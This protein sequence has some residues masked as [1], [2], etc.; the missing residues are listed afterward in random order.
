[1]SG[2][3]DGLPMRRRSPMRCLAPT[4]VMAG[5]LAVWP[6]AANDS[7]AELGTGG[8]ILSRTDAIAMT[9]EELF[10][11]MGRVTVDYVFRN[12]TDKDVEAVVAF[13]MPTIDGNPYAMPALPDGT[14]DNFL[15]FEVSVDG[16]PVTAR[17][18]QR[19]FAV[20]LDVTAVLEGAGVPVNPFLADTLDSLARLPER[21]A[22]GWIERGL[23]FID[24]YD[25]GSGWKHVRTPLWS[26]KSTYWWETSFPAGRDV[27]VSHRYRPSV[28]GTA[29]LSFFY[30]GAFQEGFD[31]YKQR[32]CIDDAFEQA[33]R[34]AAAAAPDGYPPLMEARIDYVLTT[35]GN[36]A[37]GTI[38][39]FR[40]TVDKGDPRNL[41]S[42]CG[43]GVRKT[44][45]TTFEMAAKDFYPA[46][47]LEI[48]ILH[49]PEAALP[50]RGMAPAAKLGGASRALRE[51]SMLGAKRR[52]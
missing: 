46:R 1:M 43:S 2:S 41:V 6:A 10:V 16:R 14:S 36:W 47:D 7:I 5:L 38:G 44:G 21:V 32:Y 34:R 27:R 19:A 29:G 4:A 25:D 33:V 30:D 37:L 26:L 13:P 45:T 22:Q 40:L 11:S 31:D 3:P 42:F 20:G 52:P 15:G 18:E 28:G 49:S 50:S 23:I 48:L 24:S 51:R 39:D 17:L 9:R 35:G 12:T 8:L